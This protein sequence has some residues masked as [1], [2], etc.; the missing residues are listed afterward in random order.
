MGGSCGVKML[1]VVCGLDVVY[2]SE[3]SAMEA[4]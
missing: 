3:A 1:C 2:F 4:L